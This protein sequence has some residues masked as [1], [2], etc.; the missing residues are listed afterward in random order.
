[1]PSMTI[2]IYKFL[3]KIFTILL[4][5]FYASTKKQVPHS[6]LQS[7]SMIYVNFVFIYA[8]SVHVLCLDPPEPELAHDRTRAIFTQ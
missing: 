1:M 7:R 4:V 5:V 3:N 2:V 8:I 6:P